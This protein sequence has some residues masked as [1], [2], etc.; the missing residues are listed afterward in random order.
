[1]ELLFLISFSNCSLLVHNNTIDFCVLNLYLATLLILLIS[2]NSF[3]VDPL[4]FFYMI[5]IC[6][7][8]PFQCGW[9]LF[10]VLA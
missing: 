9:V 6:L 2:S 1:M 8:L 7:L 4:G 10:H 3:L 5:V